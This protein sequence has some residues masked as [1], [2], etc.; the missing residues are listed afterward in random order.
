[1]GVEHAP[2][3]PHACWLFLA[4]ELA[5]DLQ[6]ALRRA[7]VS[8]LRA[9]CSCLRPVL[10]VRK[11]RCSQVILIDWGRPPARSGVWRCAPEGGQVQTPDAVRRVFIPSN[12][13]RRPLRS[14]GVGMPAWPDGQMGC[15]SRVAPPAST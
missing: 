7:G 6:G 8:A 9:G 10:V 1:M 11:W 2:L 12:D 15:P 14:G 13:N 4:H 3:M 5:C